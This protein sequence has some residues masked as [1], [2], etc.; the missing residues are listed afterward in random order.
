MS[1]NN[2]YDILK[3]FASL[4][5]K[6]EAPK[7]AAEKI[8][9]SVNP[10]G[11]VSEGIANIE[12]R[13]A[14]QFAESDFSKMSAG[15]QKSGKSKASADAITAAVGREKLGQREMTRRAVAGKKKA[16]HESVD[17]GIGD[18]MAKQANK[19]F[20]PGSP[21]EIAGF[22]SDKDYAQHYDTK[23]YPAAIQAIAQ[24]GGV[25]STLKPNRN[26]N[27]EVA[28]AKRQLAHIYRAKGVKIDPSNFDE[29][30]TNKIKADVAKAMGQQGVTESLQNPAQ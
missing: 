17:E 11:S 1:N 5:P 12:S 15:I 19:A 20:G 6:A 2:L 8:Y 14:K 4:T 23:E 30:I 3:N 27:A 7:P 22:A 13:L 24:G 29:L 10:R 16:T 21:T 26:T 9:E 18:W 25:G 28:R